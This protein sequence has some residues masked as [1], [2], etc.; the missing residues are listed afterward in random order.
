PP[1]WARWGSPPAPREPPAPPGRAVRACELPALVCS[2]DSSLLLCARLC[3]C[4]SSYESYNG[5]ERR[6][7]RLH[8]ILDLNPKYSFFHLDLQTRLCYNSSAATCDA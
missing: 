8:P 4:G 7:V 3:H 1:T 2:L 5:N 6:Q